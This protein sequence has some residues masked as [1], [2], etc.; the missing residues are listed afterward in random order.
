MLNKESIKLLGF[1]REEVVILEVL[2]KATPFTVTN[3]AESTKIPR[4]TVHFLL[5]KLKKRGFVEQ[6]KIGGHYEWGI[7]SEIELARKIRGLATGTEIKSGVLG[8]IESEN[9]G[10]ELYRGQKK[11]EEAYEK[12]L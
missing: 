8:G 10:I 2:R 1:L 3:L 9:I 11:V 12:I 5:N 7:V 4:T 6:I